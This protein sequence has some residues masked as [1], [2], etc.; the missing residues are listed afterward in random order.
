M[1][2]RTKSIPLSEIYVLRI[3]HWE[4][5]EYEAY[6]FFN[7]GEAWKEFT[8]TVEDMD[9]VFSGGMI[10]TDGHYYLAQTEDYCIQLC[11]FITHTDDETEAE[12]MQD[13]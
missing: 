8:Y 6:V 12:D 5:D 4:H 1:N 11:P 10:T 13:L 3:F 2:K 9:A 7:F